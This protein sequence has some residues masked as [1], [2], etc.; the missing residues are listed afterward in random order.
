MHFILFLTFEG[1][2]FGIYGPYVENP[3][4]DSRVVYYQLVNTW[5]DV[6]LFD[7]DITDIN[8]ACDAL[9]SYGDLEYF[10]AAK[11]AKLEKWIEERLHKPLFPRYKEMLE[12]LKDYCHR[13]VE[14]NTGVMIDL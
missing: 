3:E 13:A 4:S 5:D 10:D 6:D 7:D 11:C 1:V 12:V 9:L 2:S 14:L 8:D